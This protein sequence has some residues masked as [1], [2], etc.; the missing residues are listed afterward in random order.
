[1][2]GVVRTTSQIL[3]QSSFIRGQLKSLNV[4]AR[5]GSTILSAG[6]FHLVLSTGIFHWCDTLV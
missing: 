1:M 2:A 6:P 5:S 4:W 3:L